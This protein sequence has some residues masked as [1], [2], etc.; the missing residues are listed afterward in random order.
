MVDKALVEAMV[1]KAA[2]VV[3]VAMEVASAHHTDM[4]FKMA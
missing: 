3:K 4:V 1:D 2:L